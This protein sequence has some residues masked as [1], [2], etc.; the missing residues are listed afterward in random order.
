VVDDVHVLVKEERLRQIVL[1]K[2]EAFVAD[3]CSTFTSDP[4]SRL[5]TQITR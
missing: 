5:S 4:V 1:K 2:E 3:I